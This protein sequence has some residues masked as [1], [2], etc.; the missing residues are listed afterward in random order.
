MTKPNDTPT[1]RY[2]Q[3]VNANG[4][5]VT[6]HAINNWRGWRLCR[7]WV[8]GR[9]AFGCERVDLIPHGYNP[10]DAVSLGIAWLQKTQD[11]TCNCDMC[12]AL[13]NKRAK[14]RNVSK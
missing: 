5:T 12:L 11:Q 8:D 3:H 4:K 14:L 7:I 13:S 9:L 10:V 6:I 1:D 2:T